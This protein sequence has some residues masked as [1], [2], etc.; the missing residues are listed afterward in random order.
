MYASPLLRLIVLSLCALLVVSQLDIGDS[1]LTDTEGASI[2]FMGL[3]NRARPQYLKILQEGLSKRAQAEMNGASNA[4]KR[5]SRK[6]KC[7][8]DFWK[9]RGL[10]DC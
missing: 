5:R 2:G 8:A 6:D 3:L 4:A 7:M 10:V 1:D 9:G